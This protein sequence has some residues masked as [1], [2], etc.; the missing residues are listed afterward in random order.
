MPIVIDGRDLCRTETMA[1]HGFTYV[2]IGRPGSYY[3]EVG[4]AKKPLLWGS[5]RLGQP[6]SE[7]TTLMVVLTSTGTPLSK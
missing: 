2:S 3:A 6:P 7:K 4:T 1:E 5:A